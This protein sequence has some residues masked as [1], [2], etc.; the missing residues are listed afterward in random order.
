MKYNQL[1]RIVQISVIILIL[2][3]LLLGGYFVF[4]IV[5]QPSIEDKNLTYIQPYEMEYT[6]QDS[7][8][9]NTEDIVLEKIVLDHSYSMS[10][11][12][13]NPTIEYHTSDD[14][15]QSSLYI[16]A[17]PKYTTYTTF[18]LHSIQNIIE[19]MGYQEEYTI[20]DREKLDRIEDE[21]W[22]IK[23]TLSEVSGKS[24]TDVNFTQITVETE[25]YDEQEESAVIE[26]KS[27]QISFEGEI[28][29][30]DTFTGKILS[31]S[32]Q[33]E[34]PSNQDLEDLDNGDIPDDEL[35]ED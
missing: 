23:H 2:I 17:Q 3:P 12:S 9:E 19:N 27:Y 25:V 14:S 31:E 10:N 13:T 11:N 24:V 16:N 34:H 7:N 35:T 30:S 21:Y 15:D 26:L 20:S 1:K 22:W 6:I 8:L 33:T 18:E 5:T 28:E 29:S 32:V 4:S